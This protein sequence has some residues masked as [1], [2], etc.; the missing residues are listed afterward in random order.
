VIGGK[1]PWRDLYSHRFCYLTCGVV[2]F[3]GGSVVKIPPAY[4][5]DA[6]DVGLI[7]GLERSPGEGNGNLL[8]HSRLE[9]PVD[10]GAWQAIVHRVAKSW[11]QLSD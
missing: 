5:G 2:G 11:T 7:P 6:E 1:D 8:Q 9:N 10:R 4:A 3:P